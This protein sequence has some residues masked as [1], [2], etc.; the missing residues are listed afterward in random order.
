MSANSGLVVGAGVIAD[1]H[2]SGEAVVDSLHHRQRP[3]RSSN[4]QDILWKF[5]DEQVLRIAVR[6][7]YDELCGAR[8]PRA[9]NRRIYLVGHKDPEAFVF[10][11]GGQ[12]LIGGDHS[13]DAFHID[14]YIDSHVLL[15][16]GA[17]GHDQ[18][19]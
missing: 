10:K 18:N 17:A 5:I 4:K 16:L 12:Q 7:A 13:R 3:R 11:S 19:Y 9:L 1:E 6:I 8:G 2:S 14:R 15:S